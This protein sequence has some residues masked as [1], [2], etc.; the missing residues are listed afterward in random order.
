M[1]D[2]DTYLDSILEG[3]TP[4]E[5]EVQTKRKRAT[6]K[7]P[8]DAAL[9][10]GQDDTQ[11]PTRREPSPVDAATTAGSALDGILNGLATAPKTQVQD[12]STEETTPPIADPEP[13][14][15]DDQESEPATS[16][17]MQEVDPGVL[18]G[19][20]DLDLATPQDILGLPPEPTG[21]ASHM[22]LAHEVN[23][24]ASAPATQET[25]ART[26]WE[27][28]HSFAA[29]ARDI[30]ATVEITEPESGRR[31]GKSDGEHA[32]FYVRTRRRRRQKRMNRVTVTQVIGLVLLLVLG[33]GGEYEYVAK[34]ASQPV[35]TVAIPGTDIPKL[36]LVRPTR[37]AGTLFHF[38]TRGTAQS[39]PFK[40][41]RPVTLQTSARCSRPSAA[42]NVEVGVRS[43]AYQV[44]TVS[45]PVR[46]TR[47]VAAKP[48]VLKAGT[49]VVVIH[50][51]A[52]CTWSL[53]GRI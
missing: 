45:L 42:S 25:D 49:Y 4:P 40:I 31:G 23:A 48:T 3:L 14:F 8:A 44:A 22:E 26:R 2:S 29:I 12:S 6:D 47:P 1:S 19:T 35:P 36:P 39:A 30:S 46:T 43:G 41:T 9:D 53:Q 27:S 38:A 32:S 33:L 20:G 37:V 28:N 13:S 34:H 7:G 21:A 15:A 5:E 10:D 50:A 18:I 52:T 16:A 11:A 24:V 17:A 51:P